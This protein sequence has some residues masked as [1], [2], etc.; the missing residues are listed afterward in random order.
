MEDLVYCVI[1][2]IHRKRKESYWN[3]GK[4]PEWEQRWV[5]DAALYATEP[6]DEEGR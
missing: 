2:I 4:R 1:Q 5:A 6:V 3:R